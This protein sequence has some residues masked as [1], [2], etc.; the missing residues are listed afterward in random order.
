MLYAIL[1]AAFLVAATV[2]VRA[3]GLNLVLRFLMK[4]H[5]DPPNQP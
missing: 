3:A 4:S 2:F 1:I 5:T